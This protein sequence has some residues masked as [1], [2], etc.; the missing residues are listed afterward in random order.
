LFFHCRCFRLFFQLTLLAVF[1]IIALSCGDTK[2]ISCDQELPL[3]VK[4]YNEEG[5]SF[6]IFALAKMAKLDDLTAYNLAVGSQL[7]DI[8]EK[9]TAFVVE[10]ANSLHSLHGGNS[11]LISMR[12]EELLVLIE[13]SFNDRKID[14]VQIGMYIHAF[15]DAF[16]HTKELEDG[17]V[18]AY[19]AIF[20]HV[21]DG[22]KPDLIA[23]YKEKY[24]LYTSAM[25]EIFGGD[26]NSEIYQKFESYIYTMDEQNPLSAAEDFRKEIIHRYG[27]NVAIYSAM[28]SQAYECVDDGYMKNVISEIEKNIDK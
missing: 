8:L 24:L 28:L 5:H 15:G 7:P 20:G 1:S 21:F 18:I 17:S 11:D 6:T 2:R 14:L 16:A 10:V 22:I 26:I 9:Y 23:L 12:R 3:H 25:F 4:R 13:N 19:E 27:F